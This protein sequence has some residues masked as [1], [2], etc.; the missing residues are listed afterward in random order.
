MIVAMVTMWMMQVSVYQVVHM[1]T[2]RHRLVSA[3]R[4]MNM[5]RRMAG[6]LMIRCAA[7]RVRGAHI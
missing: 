2:M 3:A 6:A 7:F 5:I 1:I 4:P